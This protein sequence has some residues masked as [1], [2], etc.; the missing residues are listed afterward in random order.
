MNHQSLILRTWDCKSIEYPGTLRRRPPTRIRAATPASITTVATRR[1]RAARCRRVSPSSP[2]PTRRS[3]DLM[4]R[5]E[6]GHVKTNTGRHSKALS[7]YRLA[8]DD[9]VSD[10]LKVKP[11]DI[12]EGAGRPHRAR[13]GSRRKGYDEAAYWVLYRRGARST[14]LP[15]FVRRESQPSTAAYPESER[16][17][18]VPR[19]YGRTRDSPEGLSAC[20]SRV[21]L[22]V[23]SLLKAEHRGRSPS[24]GPPPACARRPPLHHPLH[25]V[26]LESHCGANLAPSRPCRRWPRPPRAGTGRRRRSGSLRTRT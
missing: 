20:G 16:T 26:P 4:N 19:C 25:L 10:L 15:P 14:T 23:P 21:L 13:E 1:T 22:H 12:S 6:T 24:P 3:R 18:R 9:V 7:L 2:A 17:L 11:A 5:R 8:F